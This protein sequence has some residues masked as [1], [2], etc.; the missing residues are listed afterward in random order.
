[1][2]SELSRTS[3]LPRKMHYWLE[4]GD[5]ELN[6]SLCQRFVIYPAMC[7]FVFRASASVADIYQLCVFSAEARDPVPL[8]VIIIMYGNMHCSKI[9]VHDVARRPDL[10]SGPF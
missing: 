10:Q 7:I 1:M 5:L 2:S 3:E 4:C 6:K 8:Y 9:L